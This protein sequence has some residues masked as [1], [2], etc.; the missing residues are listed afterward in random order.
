MRNTRPRPPDVRR[1]GVTAIR[2][3]TVASVAALGL[4]T[5]AGDVAVARRRRAT[6]TRR[7]A[8]PA[9]SCRCK[10][11]STRP[12]RSR[13]GPMSRLIRAG[14]SWSSA[15]RRTRPVIARW[16]SPATSRTHDPSFGTGGVFVHCQITRRRYW[17]V[18][19]TAIVAAAWLVPQAARAQTV[20]AVSGSSDPP[21]SPCS[22]AVCP[23]L[24]D[25]ALAANANQPAAAQRVPAQTTLG[26]V[27]FQIRR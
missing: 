25:A 3:R 8:P 18:V 9:G 5:G 2:L 27:Q 14:G 19:P 17:R 20:Y 26:R 4:A 16:S 23:S 21:T 7:S 15:R 13:A 11:T 12:I 1:T 10:Q 24:R 22:A 6:W